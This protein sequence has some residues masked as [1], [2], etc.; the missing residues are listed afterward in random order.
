MIEAISNGGEPPRAS[1]RDG[2]D[3]M[4]G[5]A[6]G[7]ADLAPAVAQ[8]PLGP[9]R[10]GLGG[11]NYGGRSGQPIERALQHVRAFMPEAFISD[12]LGFPYP[13]GDFT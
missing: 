6:G 7:L 1:D 13:I 9:R 4:P 8:V 12:R 11:Q 2:E 5:D 10:A 3:K